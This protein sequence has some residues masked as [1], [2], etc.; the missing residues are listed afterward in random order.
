[1]ETKKISDKAKAAS[2]RARVA[3]G[4]YYWKA[5][6]TP[7]DPCPVY[8]LMERGDETDRRNWAS[9]LAF[10]TEKAARRFVASLRESE[11]RKG[12]NGYER[13]RTRMK[14]K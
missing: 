7:G 6:D 10:P 1:M 11:V 5:S 14:T 8:K 9:G 12:A 3:P 4:Q 13:R 2:H